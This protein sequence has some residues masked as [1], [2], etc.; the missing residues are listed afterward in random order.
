MAPL[1][2][3]LSLL[4]LSASTAS[5]VT[6]DCENIIVDKQRFDLSP[7]GGPK[8]VHYLERMPPSVSNTTY[9]LDI[10]DKLPRTKGV[11]KSEECPT[12]TQ[13][14]GIETDYNPAED[15]EIIRAVKPIAGEFSTSH[16]R[17]M[18]PVFERLKGGKSHG[19]SERE[20]LRVILNGGRYPFDDRNGQ[21]QEAIIE[22]VCDRDVTGNEGFEDKERRR[23]KRDDDDDDD[24]EDG[25]GK[26][27]DLDKGQSLQFVSYKTE[28]ED[29]DE[30]GTL[31]LS[32][33]TKYACEGAAD[34]PKEPKK[35]S[36]GSWGFFT[37]FL[38]M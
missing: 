3:A 1:T 9:T 26:L 36:K 35:G 33:K 32:W 7:L 16:G 2:T 17:P 21:S 28:G 34:E 18:D 29:D 37:W 27:P 4:L 30:S 5:A 8:T 31:R 10:C 23:V 11:P 13:V 20:G 19:D 14:C 24:N 25:E 15:K 22:F 12:G 38:I 6:L